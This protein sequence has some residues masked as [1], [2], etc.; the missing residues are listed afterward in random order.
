MTRFRDEMA[1][2]P[3]PMWVITILGYVGLSVG[4]VTLFEEPGRPFYLLAFGIPLIFSVFLLLTGYVYGD[5]KRRNM[6]PLMWALLALLLPNAIGFILYFIL[7]E[8]LTYACPQ[9]GKTVGGRFAFCPYCGA[10]R[11]ASCPKC[12]SAVEPEW[13]YCPHCGTALSADQYNPAKPVPR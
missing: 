7:R 2:I 8:P 4:I 10:S 13:P 9:C 11:S 12:R 6:R 1:V 3:R 5:A